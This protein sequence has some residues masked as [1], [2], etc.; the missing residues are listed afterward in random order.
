MLFKFKKKETVLDCFTFQSNVEKYFPIQKA[1]KFIPDW[2]RNLEPP[3]FTDITKP[4]GLTTMKYCPGFISYFAESIAVP[5]W[6]YAHFKVKPVSRPEVDCASVSIISHPPTQYA[7]FLD[8]QYFHEKIDVPWCVHSKS[9]TPFILTFPTWCYS[10][11]NTPERVIN[12]PGIIDFK[13]QHSVNFQFMLKKPSTAKD[14]YVFT[15]DAGIP[16]YFLTP[17]RDEKITIKTHVV[18][19][20]EFGNLTGITKTPALNRPVAYKKMFEK[21]MGKK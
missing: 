17:L 19:R 4:W 10:A 1:S 16:L 18:T 8:S 11:K 7:G 15:F 12:L 2:Y 13:Y 21:M 6:D 20:E 14:S 9:D 3:N 5:M